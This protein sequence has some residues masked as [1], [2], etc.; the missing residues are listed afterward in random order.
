MLTLTYAYHMTITTRR[1]Y[2][3]FFPLISD[4]D[5]GKLKL[6]FFL[7]PVTD[8]T[9]IFELLI[10]YQKRVFCLPNLSSQL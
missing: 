1:Q 7:S 3:Q 8:D 10:R 4:D 9:V 6:I 2:I 5:R